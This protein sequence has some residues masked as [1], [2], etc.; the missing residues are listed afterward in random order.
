[1]HISRRRT[2]QC[3]SVAKWAH[4]SR[5]RR[6]G[7]ALI[8]IDAQYYMAG[9]RGAPDNAA[10]YPLACGEVGFKADRRDAPPAARRARRR[11]TCV[12]HPLHR[13]PDQR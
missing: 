5:R 10:K 9:I 8:V 3:S 7:P 6:A 12:L 13:R 11:R 2:A 1:M 4:A